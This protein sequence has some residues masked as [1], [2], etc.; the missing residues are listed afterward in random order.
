MV[1]NKACRTSHESCSPRRIQQGKPFDDS[2]SNNNNKGKE[3]NNA[4]SRNCVCLRV[5]S[6]ACFLVFVYFVT[7]GGGQ[8]KRKQNDAKVTTAT[9]NK[10]REDCGGC[11]FSSLF[12]S[13]P[14]LLL[15]FYALTRFYIHISTK[16]LLYAF[17]NKCNGL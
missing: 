5:Y 6:A 7:A 13:M 15:I 1:C 10:Q 16:Y 8:S 9:N 14:F 12:F 4:R 11:H 2:S 17:K 3:I